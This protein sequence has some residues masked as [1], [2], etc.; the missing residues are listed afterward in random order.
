MKVLTKK[1]MMRYVPW[2]VN[3]RFA[4]LKKNLRNSIIMI[5]NERPLTFYT[6]NKT[7]IHVIIIIRL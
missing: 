7:E 3:T 4:Q 2:E 1:T 6:N 5:H